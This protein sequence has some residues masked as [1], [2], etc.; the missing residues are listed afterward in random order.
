MQRDYSDNTTPAPTVSPPSLSKIRPIDLLVVK[1]SSG[2]T[3]ACVD[4]ADDR[5]L[6]CT[7]ADEP[8]ESI[9]D[10]ASQKLSV[11]VQ[12]EAHLGFC[13]STVPVTLSIVALSLEMVAGISLL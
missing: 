13:L 2:T 12:I 3:A 9:L 10:N 8:E 11:V 1:G 5:S 7:R 4:E 6:I